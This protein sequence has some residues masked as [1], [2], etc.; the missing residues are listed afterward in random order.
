MR[1]REHAALS[2]Y[3]RSCADALG[4]R[5]WLIVVDRTPCD[6]GSNAQSYLVYGRKLARLSFCRDFRDHKPEHQ[7]QTVV[8]ELIHCHFAAV[9]NMAEHDL[10]P[11]I[12]NAAASVFFASFPQAD[13][14][15]R[16]RARGVDR[17]DAPVDEVGALMGQTVHTYPVDDLI[18]H[19]TDGR[20]CPCGPTTEPVPCD[21][22][23]VGWSVVHHSLDGRE[24]DEDGHDRASCPGCV[25]RAAGIR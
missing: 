25:A 20:D 11:Q 12:G 15:R 19:L 1:K 14:V 5:D 2:D 4:L 24:H 6:D 21:D 22:G 3:V 10:E 7:R 9:D 18:E 17:A 8:H 16:R 13:G 23:S